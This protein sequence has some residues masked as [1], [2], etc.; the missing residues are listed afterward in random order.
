MKLGRQNS[1]DVAELEPKNRFFAA[2]CAI[3][4]YEL[5]PGNAVSLFSEVDLTRIERLRRLAAESGAPVPSY[6]AFVV[7]AMAL[8]LGEFP[9]ANRRI[10]RRLLGRPR[11]Q[12]FH[13]IDAVVLS[14]RKLPDA[15]MVTSMN[16][17]RDADTLSVESISQE[18]AVLGASDVTTNRQWRLLTRIVTRLPMWLTRLVLRMPP[19][20]PSLWVKYRG[21]SFVVTGHAQSGVD[22]VAATWPWAL[23]V[24]FGA[25]RARPRIR[26]G[27]FV[28]CPSFTLSLN[29]DR[30]LMAGAPAARFFARVLDLLSQPVAEMERTDRAVS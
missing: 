7:K 5:V 17:L 22:I 1:S 6:I 27:E 23:G 15:P 18:L 14:D 24:S 12:R 8:A 30:R 28:P 13:R 26:D 11:V 25:V 29:F 10:F 9:Y 20:F 4:D 3:S 19:L 16:M 2:L 21:G